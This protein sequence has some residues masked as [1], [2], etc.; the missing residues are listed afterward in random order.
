[1]TR[2]DYFAKTLGILSSQAKYARRL[3]FKLAYHNGSATVP[4]AKG[5]DAINKSQIGRGDGFVAAFLN[6]T[7]LN[8]DHGG[9][10]AA[11]LFGIGK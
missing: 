5:K 8:A 1:M 6:I 3:S 4:P 10:N 7:K 2:R 11:E 9:A